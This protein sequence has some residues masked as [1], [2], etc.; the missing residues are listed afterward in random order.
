MANLNLKKYCC[1]DCC[2]GFYKIQYFDRHLASDKHNLRISKDKVNL[3][4]PLMQ[5]LLLK[6]IRV[7]AVSNI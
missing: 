2:C 1:D 3:H 6:K 5:K 4:L 7:E